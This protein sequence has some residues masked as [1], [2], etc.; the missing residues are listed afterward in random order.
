ML[1]ELRN[2]GV[3]NHSAQMSRLRAQLILQANKR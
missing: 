1:L 3:L 2:E